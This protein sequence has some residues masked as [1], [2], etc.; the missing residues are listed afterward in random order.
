M[1]EINLPVSVLI[2]NSIP[3][4][5]VKFEPNSAPTAEPTNPPITVAMSDSG[6]ES[7]TLFPAAPP[8]I[9]QR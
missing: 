7:V 6:Y 2:N 3:S 5:L 4:F 8:I 1:I 9:L